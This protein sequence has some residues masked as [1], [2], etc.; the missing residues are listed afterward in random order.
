VLVIDGE[1]LRELVPMA[2][3]VVAVRE[4]FIGVSC[5]QFWQPLRLCHEDQTLVMAAADADGI[6][7]V[8]KVVSIRPGNPSRGLPTIQASVVWHDGESGR[9]TAVLDGD[10]VTALRTGAASG[11]ATAELAEPGA[12]VLAVIGAGCQAP[13]Q[14]QAV[15]AVRPIDTVRIAS[16]TRESA[17]RLAAQIAAGGD[18]AVEVCATPAEA[19]SGAHVV[20]C[21]TSASE[22]LFPASALG[23]RVHI[24]AVGSFRP[25]MREL[26]SDVLG[27]ASLVVVDQ[28]EAAQKEAGELIR[29]LEDGTLAPD[30]LVEIGDLLQSGEPA[31][32]DGIT[33]F[34]SVG[35]AAQDWAVARL[36]VARATAGAAL[37]GGRP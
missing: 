21:A 16:R 1:A 34:K 12:T 7:T 4:A 36:A 8:V 6:G 31:R 20:C 10:T 32:R 25:E 9:P 30:A 33:V 13:D 22:P 5:G 19:V 28:R 27:S 15:R 29:A 35:L 2:D 37:E 17:D 18:V 24:N 26:G 23:T 11:V 14:V 3:A